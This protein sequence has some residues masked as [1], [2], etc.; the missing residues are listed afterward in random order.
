[1]LLYVL[2]AITIE[3]YEHKLSLRQNLGYTA[4]ES[5][6]LREQGGLSLCP[7]PYEP[8]IAGFL[9]LEGGPKKGGMVL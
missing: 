5:K 8:K 1:M 2:Y 4:P 9:G 3:Y 7:K 6:Y